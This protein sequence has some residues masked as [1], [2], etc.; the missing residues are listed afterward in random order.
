MKS[1]GQIFDEARARREQRSQPWV[2]RKMT[3]GIC[4]GIMGYTFYVAV[5]RVCVPAIRREGSA[6]M[7]FSTGGTCSYV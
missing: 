5:G 7:G 2:A 3:I 6:I 1:F 4:G